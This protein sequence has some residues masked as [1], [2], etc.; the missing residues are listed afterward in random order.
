MKKFLL[1]VSFVLLSQLTLAED[2]NQTSHAN[3]QETQTAA[4]STAQAETKPVV[5]EKKSKLF[6]YISAC[7]PGR[8]LPAE[9]LTRPISK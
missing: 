5:E 3:T 8:S 7:L 1:V 9:L 4:S 2:S 6:E